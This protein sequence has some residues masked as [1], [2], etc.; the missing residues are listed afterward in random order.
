MKMRRDLFARRRFAVRAVLGLLKYKEVDM[1][2]GY[3][4]TTADEDTGKLCTRCDE[5]THKKLYIYSLSLA[6]GST[7]S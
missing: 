3:G 1:R 6:P 2:R 4:T 5:V 7:L